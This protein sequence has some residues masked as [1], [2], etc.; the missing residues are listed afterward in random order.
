MPWLVPVNK[1]ERLERVQG[2]P[3]V[4]FSNSRLVP[5]QSLR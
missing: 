5:R 4:S 2:R 1:L 3:E